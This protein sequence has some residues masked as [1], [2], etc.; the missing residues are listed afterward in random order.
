MHR[1]LARL[2]RFAL[3][4]VVALPLHAQTPAGKHIMYRVHGPN[5]ATVYLLGSVHLLTP[6]AGKLPPIVD[7]AFAHAQ[8]IAFETSLDSVVARAPEMVALAR[9]APGSSLRTMLSP[10]AATK[11]D[12]LLHLYGM[13]LD[14]VAMFKPWFVSLLMTSLTMQKAGFQADYGVDMQLDKRAKQAGKPVIGLEGVD[15]QLHLFDNLS[16]AQQERMLVA[17]KGPDAAVAEMTSLKDAW[18]AGDA[19]RLDSMLN[20]SAEMSPEMLDVMVV[21][22]NRSWIPEIESL[23]KGKTDALVVVGAAHL[24]GKT[25]IVQMLRDKGYTVEQ[26]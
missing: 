15:L 19:A 25:G 26:I 20:A 21:R 17:S 13:S 6:E 11:T 1:L 18:L 5:G 24:V 16:A 7:T 10:A 14:Q 9:V 12:S 22:R 2:G 8:T 23:I 3:A 4:I